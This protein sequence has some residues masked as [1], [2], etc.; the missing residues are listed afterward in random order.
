M[1][2]TSKLSSPVYVYALGGLGEVGKNSYVI[3]NDNT[4][5]L[6]D[7]GIRFPEDSMTGIDYVIPDY[8]YLRNN[9]KKFKALFITHGHEDHIGGIPFLMQVAH[10]PVVYAPPL[11]AQLIRHKLQMMRIRTE[12]KIVEYKEDDIIQIDDFTVSFYHVTHSIPD[13][14]GICVDTSEGRV[15]TTGDFKIDLTP[16]GPNINLGKM[17]KI[18][19]EGVD[20]L[21][22]DSTNAEH[23]GH[24]PSERNV[25]SAINEIFALTTG[26]LIIST[27]SSNISRIQQIVEAS[28]KYGRK[29]AVIGRSME[30]VINVSRELGYIKMPDKSLVNVEDINTLKPSETCIL[31][32]GSQGEPMAALSRIADGTHKDVK[33]IP[34]DTVVFSSSPIPGNGVE[35][36]KVVNKLT[37]LGAKVLTNSILREIHSSGHP[38]RLE[39]QLVLRIFHPNYFM[40]IHGEYRMLKLHGDLATTVGVDPNHVFICKNGESLMLK[41]HKVDRGPTIPAESIYINGNSVEG[42]SDA[43]ILDR[44]RLAE[45]GMC[46]VLIPLDATNNK[47]L[48][49]VALYTRGFITHDTSKLI[50]D[51]TVLINKEI[52][53]LF[54]RRTTTYNEIKTLTKQVLE[55]FFFEK[56]GRN[57]MIIPLIMNKGE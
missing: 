19:S 6:I 22:S 36:D 44:K 2:T 24:T 12:L 37:R 8:S 38:S 35:I 48:D 7:A 21:L 57:P 41:D 54:K 56:T 32:T 52:N 29:I 40:P 5:I 11:A 42:I 17:A 13:S 4:L 31:C 26:R 55:P 1:A 47:L 3:E 49:K 9:N 43:V 16:I 39:L 25:I 23:E 10:I 30:R 14:F 51:A 18:G 50:P 20:L 53:D 45:D 33:I 34:G 28:L 27:F 15:V 46:A